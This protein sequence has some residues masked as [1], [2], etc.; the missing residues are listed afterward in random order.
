MTTSIVRLVK[1][2]TIWHKHIPWFSVHIGQDCLIRRAL[3]SA[4]TAQWGVRMVSLES[5]KLQSNR[6]LSLTEMFRI[7]GFYP[8]N[9]EAGNSLGSSENRT[10]HLNWGRGQSKSS[11]DQNYLVLCVCESSTHTHTHT[12]S[13][14]TQVYCSYSKITFNKDTCNQLCNGE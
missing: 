14:G 3:H 13:R 8:E 6:G 2:K 9:S 11:L 1:I 12:H 5:V 4:Q 7:G 10:R